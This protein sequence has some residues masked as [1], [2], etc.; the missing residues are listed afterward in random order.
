MFVLWEVSR[1][2]WF[3]IN[4]VWVSRKKKNYQSYPVYWLF[5]DYKLYNVYH[6][7]MHAESS[8]W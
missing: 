5:M 4:F 1:K 3:E 7:F 6:Y 8:I 2:I